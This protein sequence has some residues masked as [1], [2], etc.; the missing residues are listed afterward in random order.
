MMA[1]FI[2][3]HKCP[4]LAQAGPAVSHGISGSSKCWLLS[5]DVVAVVLT[6]VDCFVVV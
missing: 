1:W 5:F 4:R 2:A 6:I 3:R